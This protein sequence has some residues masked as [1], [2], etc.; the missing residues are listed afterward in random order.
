MSEVNKM[1]D[2]LTVV[3]PTEPCGEWTGIGGVNISGARETS[4]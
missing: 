2:A 1:K 4:A 3:R